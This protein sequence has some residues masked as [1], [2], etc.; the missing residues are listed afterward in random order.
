MAYKNLDKEKS[1]QKNYHKN[2]KNNI[3][4]EQKDKLKD[5]FKEFDNVEP[6][7]KKYVI[8][9]GDLKHDMKINDQINWY[10]YLFKFLRYTLEN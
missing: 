2:Y 7:L 4:L 8:I 9:F 3:L 1:Y 10:S 6:A 5:I